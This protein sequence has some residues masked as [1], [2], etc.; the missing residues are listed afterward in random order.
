MNPRESQAEAVYLLGAP[1][2]ERAEIER[3]LEPLVELDP[4]LL[5]PGR[6]T[7]SELLARLH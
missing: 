1:D 7:V 2:P 3:L 6:G 4:E 5:V